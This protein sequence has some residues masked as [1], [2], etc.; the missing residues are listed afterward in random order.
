[1]EIIVQN[2][3]CFIQSLYEKYFDRHVY[4]NNLS[5]LE[6]RPL[7]SSGRNAST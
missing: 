4:G 3:Q 7:N 5:P 1:M 6:T 2:P